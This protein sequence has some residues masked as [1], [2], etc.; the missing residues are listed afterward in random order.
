MT[1]SGLLNGLDGVVAAEERLIFMT[2]NYLDRLDPALTRPGR[3]D[4]LQ[5]IG[6]ASKEQ[7][8][9]MF[10][11]FYEHEEELCTAFVEKLDAGYMIGRISPA[12]L[13]GHFVFH[14]DS[15]KDAVENIETLFKH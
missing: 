5:F 13:Q 8:R 12:E 4:R 10:L 2:T 11:R 3:V 15:A 7:V 1:L 14:K 6:N 9:K